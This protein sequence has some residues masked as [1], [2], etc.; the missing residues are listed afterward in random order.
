MEDVAREAGVSLV[1][2]SRAINLPDMLAP[3]TL[4]QVREAI[5]RLRYVPNLTAGSLASSRSRI[6]AAVVP[7]LASSIFS[8]TIDGLSQALVKARY[9]LLARADALPGHEERH[10]STPSSAGASMAWC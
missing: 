7:T 10:W 6:V 3:A 8:D 4:A 1:T 9:Q 5:E 2:V